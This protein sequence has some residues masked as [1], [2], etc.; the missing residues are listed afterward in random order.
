MK[1]AAVRLRGVQIEAVLVLAALSAGC[2]YDP[3]FGF[4]IQEGDIGA[5]RQAFIDHQCHQCHG[6]AGVRLPALSGASPP[7]FELGGETTT[8]K[9]YAELMTG[10]I[11]PNHFISEGFRDQQLRL[12]AGLPLESPMP[13]PHIDNMT[14][15][16]LI[17]LVAFLDSRYILIDGYDSGD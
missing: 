12:N 10:I 11:N 9:S 16:Q 7:I 1:E 17:D 5:G 2:A 13:L 3:S 6:V 14:V 4:P 15:R 8:I